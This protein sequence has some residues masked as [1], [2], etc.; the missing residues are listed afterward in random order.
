VDFLVLVR[1]L[2]D[3]VCPSGEF[4]KGDIIEDENETLIIRGLAE[5]IEEAKEG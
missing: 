5:P 4:K 3:L 1:L 2:Y